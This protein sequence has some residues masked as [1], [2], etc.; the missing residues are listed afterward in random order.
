MKAFVYRASVWDEDEK[1]I[2]LTIDTLEELKNLYKVFKH[3]LI[4]S[5]KEN[6]ISIL[7]YDDYIE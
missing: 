1:P 6:G 4:I 2:E 7:V 3:E 5:F